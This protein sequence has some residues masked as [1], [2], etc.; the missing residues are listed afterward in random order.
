MQ[1]FEAQAPRWSVFFGSLCL[2]GWF[3]LVMRLHMARDTHD[4]STSSSA[5]VLPSPSD[6]LQD[7]KTQNCKIA[8]VE[9]LLVG[10]KLGGSVFKCQGLQHSEEVV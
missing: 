7:L 10:T 8:R 6:L 1:C 4:I 2:F 5:K 3:E 9:D